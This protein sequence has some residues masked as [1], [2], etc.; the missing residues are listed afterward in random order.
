MARHR[1]NEN[2]HMMWFDTD[3]EYHQYLKRKNLPAVII[4]II[5]AIIYLFSNIGH[6][7]EKEEQPEVT[8]EEQIV[9]EIKE[10]TY[11][12][13]VKTENSIEANTD[14]EQYTQ[15]EFADENQQ[16]Q[17]QT[18]IQSESQFAL[19]TEN[20]VTEEV[21]S[22]VVDNEF[23]ESD[24]TFE[25][26]V[27]DYSKQRVFDIVE[28]MPSFPDGESELLEYI[29]K[30]IKYPQ[31]ARESGIQ[32]RVFVNFIVEPDGSVSN[33]KIIRGIGSGCDEEALRVVKSLPKFN[34]GKQRGKAVRVSYTIPINFKLQ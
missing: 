13:S 6:D 3:E 9:P 10:T 18:L 26:K 27:E 2:G 24:N 16:N 15:L 17:E 7:G 5:V 34:P 19:E 14:N 11:T 29:A 21:V 20:K 32:G 25:A 4:V 30:N 8:A 23:F 33:V 12:Y 1:I 22:E 28:E 31:M